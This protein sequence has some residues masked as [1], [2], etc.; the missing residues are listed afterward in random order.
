[1][2]LPQVNATKTHCA[3]GH[4]LTGDNLK[5]LHRSDGRT[6][7]VCRECA[8]RRSRDHFKRSYVHHPRQKKTPPETKVR[9]VRPPVMRVFDRL[10]IDK[11]GCWEWPGATSNG[12]GIIQ[13]GRKIGTDRVHRV[14]YRYVFGSIPEGLDVMHTCHNRVCARP[15]H[16]RVGTRSENM[17]M[18]QV[19]GR[20][21]RK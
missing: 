21:K 20:L 14:V 7:R 2:D 17:K 8:N 18:S 4:A 9:L 11:D 3:Y 16:L 12:Y 10:V 15:S 19:A 13:L 5:V 6:E 1:M